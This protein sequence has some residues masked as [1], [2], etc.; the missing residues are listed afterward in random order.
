MSK[1]NAT[2]GEMQNK[3]ATVNSNT[4][5]SAVSGNATAGVI[6]TDRQAGSANIEDTP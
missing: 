2:L 1:V 4:P 5:Q 3:S 6:A